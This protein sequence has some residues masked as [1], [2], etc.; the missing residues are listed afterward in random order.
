MTLVFSKG[1][2]VDVAIPAG[3]EYVWNNSEKL[4]Y[5]MAYCFAKDVKGMSEEKAIQ[6]AEGVVMKRLYPGIVYPQT[7]EKELQ[8]LYHSYD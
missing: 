7:F 8:T 3:Q 6:V 1:E 2:W 4:Y 5:A